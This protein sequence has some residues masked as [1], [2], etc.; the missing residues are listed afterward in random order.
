[1]TITMHRRPRSRRPHRGR[2]RPVFRLPGSGV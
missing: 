2:C 1:M